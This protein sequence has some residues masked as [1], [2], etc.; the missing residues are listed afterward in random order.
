MAKVLH[1]QRKLYQIVKNDSTK[2]MCIGG[3]PNSLKKDVC[4]KNS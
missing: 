3:N 1:F 4:Q 2:R